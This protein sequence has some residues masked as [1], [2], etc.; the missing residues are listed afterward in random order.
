MAG[1]RSDLVANGCRNITELGRDAFLG[2]APACVFTFGACHIFAAALH[3]RLVPRIPALRVYHLYNRNED[4]VHVVTGKDVGPF[5][6]ANLTWLTLEQLAAYWERGPLYLAPHARIRD[7]ILPAA[8]DEKRLLPV[9]NRFKRTLSTQDVNEQTTKPTVE[10]TKSHLNRAPILSEYER[11]A[12]DVLEE[13]E[14][15]SF[16]A[17][18]GRFAGFTIP[19][20][21]EGEDKNYLPDFVVR[22]RNEVDPKSWTGR[23]VKSKPEQ[24]DPCPRNDVSTVPSSKPRLVLM[25]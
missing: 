25:P 20:K 2:Q 1:T 10:L 6:D 14:L 7:N 21:H 3:R 12:I 9:L 22:L 8:T 15:V 18:N 19:Y 11:A 4:L 5:T 17:P 23:I 13:S 24:Y 16:Y